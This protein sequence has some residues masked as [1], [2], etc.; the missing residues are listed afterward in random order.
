MPLITSLIKS[1]FNVSK[2][3]VVIILVTLSMIEVTCRLL[4]VSESLEFQAVNAT[5]PYAH[6]LPNRTVLRSIGWN[7][8]NI[9]E[10]KINN[11]GYLSGIDY[12][13][14]SDKKRIVVIGDSYVEAFQVKDSE[15]LPGYLDSLLPK[16]FDVY[17]IGVSGSPLTQYLAFARL[18]KEKFSPKLFVFVVIANDF[19]ESLL[20]YKNAPGLHYY[21]ESFDLVRVDYDPPVLMKI[22]RHSA[23]M[24]YLYLNLRL[25]DRLSSFSFDNIFSSPSQIPSETRRM[26]TRAHLNW[27]LADDQPRIRRSESVVPHFFEDLLDIVGSTPT[28]FLLDANRHAIYFGRP[29]NNPVGFF[30]HMFGHFLKMCQKAGHEC[31]DMTKT[32]AENYRVNKKHFEFDNNWHWNALGHRLAAHEIFKRISVIP[33][34][35]T[36]PQVVGSCLESE[37]RLNKNEP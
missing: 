10:K 5:Q 14:N 3:T 21:D 9:T 36:P 26:L 32:F 23:F 30:D 7:L 37:F 1:V 28:I 8:S 6:F 29:K 16:D 18:A 35:A 2:T 33:C 25:P 12:S 27:S 22:F 17:G 20:Y 19:D 34:P 31:I 4:P 24:R 13:A 11:Y 15:A